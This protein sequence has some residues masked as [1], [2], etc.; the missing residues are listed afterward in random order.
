MDAP[1]VCVGGG[2]SYSWS[3]VAAGRSA[4]SPLRRALLTVPPDK[5]E[6]CVK[7]F[8]AC[9]MLHVE[10]PA[11]G[12]CG[13]QP[14]DTVLRSELAGYR[15]RVRPLAPFVAL[16]PRTGQASR[17]PR[18]D[19]AGAVHRR[20]PPSQSGRGIQPS[21]ADGWCCRAGA[22]TAMLVH[23]RP[24]RSCQDPWHA[25]MV[26]GG[27][28][29]PPGPHHRRRPTPPSEHR[30]APSTYN[31]DLNRRMYNRFSFWVRTQ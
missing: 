5:A 23:T 9:C 26:P 17:S 7:A 30:P 4:H 20:G 11:E 31:Q 3:G 29:M 24:H 13:R 16:K 8:D 21:G 2:G 19:V 12:C 15:V 25:P 6:S 1:E 18:E 27:P 10:G 28:P 14:L 22:L